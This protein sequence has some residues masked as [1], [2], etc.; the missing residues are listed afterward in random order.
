MGCC[1]SGTNEDPRELKPVEM[2]AVVAE[3]ALPRYS[4]E[5]LR[6]ATG[7]WRTKL[8]E[9]GFGAVYNGM[10]LLPRIGGDGEGGE[11][12]GGDGE[13]SGGGD[14]GEEGGDD[15]KGSNGGEGRGDHGEGDGGGGDDRNEEEVEGGMDGLEVVEAGGREFV[16]VA[17]KMCLTDDDESGAREQLLMSYGH[18]RTL[19]PK[20]ADF[21]LA[22]TCQDRTHVTTRVAGSI[23][24][25]DPAYFERG[26]L[27]TH[28]D[29]Y[30]FGIFLLELV[31]G[32]GVLDESFSGLRELLQDL[33]FREYDEL[34][35]RNLEGQWTEEQAEVLVGMMRDAI[36]SDWADRPT[37]EQLLVKW[38]NN[39]N[40]E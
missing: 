25:M 27:T 40:L 12:G 7:D 1:F 13:R 9:G 8:G 21:G 23:G 6:Q 28:C 34:I 14:G 17:V 30:A 11:G 29:T 39:L 4:Q 10:L 20:V 22:K 18:E 16:P 5:E 3:G 32:R 15:V 35:D 38:R 2:K 37:T 19:V 36:Q 26:F 31:A 33:A 24:Y